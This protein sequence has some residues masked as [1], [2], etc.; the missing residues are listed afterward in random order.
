MIIPTEHV[1]GAL[2]SISYPHLRS[3]PHTPLPALVSCG[4]I[5]TMVLWPRDTAHVNLLKRPALLV[6][7]DDLSTLLPTQAM[8][9][10]TSLSRELC[11][12]LPQHRRRYRFDGQSSL[13][14]PANEPRRPAT[15]HG[16][17]STR[18]SFHSDGQTVHSTRPRTVLDGS[19]ARKANLTWRSRSSSELEVCNT[20][21]SQSL[22]RSEAP[23]FHHQ[24]TQQ[25]ASPV[26]ALLK[27]SLA[28]LAEETRIKSS[29]Q[30]LSN[31]PPGPE[32][33]R[34]SSYPA[35]RDGS[36]AVAQRGPRKLLPL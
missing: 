18:Q 19:L 13:H 14:S 3:S 10:C 24:R 4:N 23:R 1:P 22:R 25:T 27:A 8:Q 35:M 34:A 12:Q 30:V 28:D 36:A 16:D 11:M 21:R 31:L 6:S 2:P 7:E 26:L 32:L 5:D 9:C 33:V 20:Y 15:V 17:L 29:S